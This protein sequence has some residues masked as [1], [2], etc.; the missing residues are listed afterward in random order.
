MKDSFQLLKE[1][2]GAARQ[3]F[4]VNTGKMPN[5]EKFKTKE[6]TILNKM[7]GKGC[8][9]VDKIQITY[10]NTLSGIQ[11]TSVTVAYIIFKDTQGRFIPKMIKGAYDGTNDM[12]KDYQ[13]TFTSFGYGTPINFKY[14]NTFK[15]IIK[16]NMS[17][18]SVTRSVVKAVMTKKKYLPIKWN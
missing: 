18:S 14:D 6:T 3:Q 16:S 10:K 13:K 9:V 11:P 1:G 5:K 7:K 4:L 2:S 12:T 15:K 17:G 8:K